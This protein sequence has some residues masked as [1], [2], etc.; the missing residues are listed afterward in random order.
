LKKQNIIQQ[1][2][3]QLHAAGMAAERL[4]NSF[5]A[6][7][8]SAAKGTA[9]FGFARAEAN[10]LGLDLLTASDAYLKLTASA[11]GTALEGQKTRDI[12]SA[13]SGAGRALGL[14]GD[15]MGG[16]LLAISQ[17]MSKGTVQAEELRGQ[18]AER[19]PGALNIAARA[20]KVSTVELGK[21]L[22]GGKVISEDFLPL[23]AAELQKTFPPGEKA[24][25]G[26]TAE[27]MRLK[28]AWYELKTT[29]M[30]GGGESMFTNSIKGMKDMVV[31][32]D[33]FYGRM[34]GAY[35]LLKDFVKNP[36]NPNLG[37]TTNVAKLPP[38]TAFDT[39]MT[40]L[41]ETGTGIGALVDRGRVGSMTPTMSVDLE[42]RNAQEAEMAA[43]KK[44]KP[45][46]YSRENDL[47]LVNIEKYASMMKEQEQ[48]FYDL[49]QDME[50]TAQ[51]AANVFNI[52]SF[53][54]ELKTDRYKVTPLSKYGINTAYHGIKQDGATPID[55]AQAGINKDRV[56]SFMS[57]MDSNIKYSK[58]DTY[59]AESDQLLKEQSE[60]EK[61]IGEMLKN[62]VMSV[63]EA[64][65]AK[66]KSDEEYAAAKKKLDD[67]T[68]KTALNSLG[69]SLTSL[70]NTLMQGNKEQFEIGK[71]VAI[72]GATV[73]MI[74]G[75]V[76]AFTAMAS[77]PY[78]GPAL[79]TLAAAAAIAA[80]TMNIAQ[81]SSQQF[82]GRALGGPVMAGQTY[83]VN[84][85]RST[86]GPEYFTPG[87][88]GTITPANKIGG[89]STS[90]TQVF[91][92][93]TG[94]A[95]TVRAEV[96]RMMPMFRAQAVSAV[97]QAQRSGQMQ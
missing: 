34:S 25:T 18:L 24:M 49:G 48:A 27:T 97:Y 29:V 54:P 71:K 37:G 82:P 39:A 88:S 62:G 38:L 35:R 43:A 12:F 5:E 57:S 47:L 10:R 4:R 36:M 61:R 14:S 16:A 23:F 45:K 92:I 52:N 56:N 50:K 79:G 40:G 11:R 93:S 77:I 80:G 87:V 13:V 96:S 19:L 64:N 33:T 1:V 26:M 17:M 46:K 42:A 30:E 95:D 59:G 28:T 89:N 94:V 20:M 70:G 9:E 53:V 31:E 75:A 58:G 3:T 69:N 22:E 85:N 67:D 2:I 44:I 68:A 41:P 72:A 15:Q 81:I 84:E 65:D 51:A 76:S 74:T 90:V 8:G 63:E 78:V 7:T 21:M 83:I 86:Q 66:L 91:Q 73:Q 6:A 55:P 32:A 60:R